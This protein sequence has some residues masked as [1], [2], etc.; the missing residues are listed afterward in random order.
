M[1]FSLSHS[2]LELERMLMELVEHFLKGRM[3]HD[4]IEDMGHLQTRRHKQVSLSKK[5]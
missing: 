5:I 2:W 4:I 1:A 3:M